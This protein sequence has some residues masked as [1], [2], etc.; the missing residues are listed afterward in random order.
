LN[1]HDVFNKINK[2]YK[3]KNIRKV[4]ENSRGRYYINIPKEVRKFV[5]DEYRKPT[6]K[7]GFEPFENHF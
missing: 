6:N 5:E 2:K 4:I 3:N 7:Y 1:V